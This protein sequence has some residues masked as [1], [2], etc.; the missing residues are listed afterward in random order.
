[1]K[2]SKDDYIPATDSGGGAEGRSDLQSSSPAT[3]LKCFSFKVSRGI[4]LAMHMP[5]M[6]VSGIPIP[7]PLLSKAAWIFAAD[8]AALRSNGRM[9]N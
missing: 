4:L 5:A 2:N 9:S 6:S 3:L 1:M 7:A 8:V